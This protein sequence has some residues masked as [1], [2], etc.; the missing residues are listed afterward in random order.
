MKHDASEYTEDDPTKIYGNNK[1]WF[2]LRFLSG[3]KYYHIFLAFILISIP[4]I[5]MLV[6]LV[7]T[8]KNISNTFPILITTILYII[9]IINMLFGGFTDPGI[10]P[11][12]GKD[13]EYNPNNP[14]LKYRINGHILTIN[15]C[16]SCSLFRPPRTS[17]CSSCDNCVERFDHHCFWLG[18][19]IGKRNYRYFYFLLLSI[20]ISALFQIFYSLYFIIKQTKKI[21]NKENYNIKLLIGLSAVCLF[22]L[23][24]FVFFLAKLIVTHTYLLFTNTTFYEH[25]K[26]KH[27]KVPNLNPFNKNILYTWKNV[28]LNKINKSFLLS[29]L[30]EKKKDDDKN[31]YYKSDTI[32]ENSKLKNDVKS[33]GK[34]TENFTESNLNGVVFKSGIFNHNQSPSKS[35]IFNSY[36]SDGKDNNEKI[37]K[38]GEKEIKHIPLNQLPN[39]NFLS[40][41]FSEDANEIEEEAKNNDESIKFNNSISIV[42]NNEI[43]EIVNEK[44][45]ENEDKKKDNLEKDNKAQSNNSIQ[46]KKINSSKISES[47]N[48]DIQ[49]NEEDNNQIIYVHKNES[50][51]SRETNPNFDHAD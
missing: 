24:F 17:H 3:Q 41:N 28:V 33:S 21:Q 1:L 45:K 11:R 15:Y 35:V 30:T 29:Y 25:V 13:F 32:N 12:Q 4:Y 8:H 6:I 9:Q 18:T 20:S 26:K 51:I 50:N 10:L 43:I 27:K 23:L 34:K 49:N 39:F 36:K 14:N 47:Q 48:N 46:I 37:E 5:G 22:D 7:K 16:Y 40:S 2:N 38:I 31:I 44:E 42:N 19:C